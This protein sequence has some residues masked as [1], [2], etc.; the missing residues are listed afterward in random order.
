MEKPVR[1]S[2]ESGVVDRILIEEEVAERGGLLATVWDWTKSLLVARNSNGKVQ[3]LVKPED[4][5]ADRL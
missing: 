5:R 4:S 2:N 3:V 1:S